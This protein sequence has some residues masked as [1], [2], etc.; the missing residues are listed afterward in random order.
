VI[1]AKEGEPALHG[2]P[3]AEQRGV[4]VEHPEVVDGA[5]PQ[6]CEAAAS[7]GSSGGSELIEAAPDAAGA[8][9]DHRAHVVRDDHQ[10]RW[11]SKRP[12]K[13]RRPMANDVS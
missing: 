7:S 11:R 10:V 3:G 9:G 5:P 6:A 2:V 8:E 4:A 1:R 13:T 12:E